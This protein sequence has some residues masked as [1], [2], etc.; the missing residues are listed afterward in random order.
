MTTVSHSLYAEQVDD[1]LHDLISVHDRLLADLP[2]PAPS[3]PGSVGISKARTLRRTGLPS[4]RAV[5]RIDA[6]LDIYL[7]LQHS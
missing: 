3:L 7:E 5:T 4:S 6:I 1:G 2:R